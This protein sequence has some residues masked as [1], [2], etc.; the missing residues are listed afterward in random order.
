MSKI[1]DQIKPDAQNLKS[2]VHSTHSEAEEEKDVKTENLKGNKVLLNILHE[3]ITQN[4]QFEMSKLKDRPE[5]SVKN[6]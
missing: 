5:I 1:S 3:I 2:E 6:I 4:S